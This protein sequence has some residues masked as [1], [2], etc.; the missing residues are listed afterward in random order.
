M[1]K[2][3]H[4]QTFS[5][6]IEKTVS[7]LVLATVLFGAMPAHAAKTQNASGLSAI[8]VADAETTQSG[9]SRFDGFVIPTADYQPLPA[10]ASRTYR[11]DMTAYTSSVEECDADPFTTADGSRPRNGIVAT[12]FL[13][14]G[15]RV[16]IPSLFGDK[17]LTVHDRMNKRYNRRIA[18][19]MEKKEDMREFGIH[20]NVTVEVIE[21]GDNATQWKKA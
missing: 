12:N 11:V 20:R 15:T 17:I 3:D 21:W 10:Y 2:T 19:W 16:R 13:P 4:I 7:V 18:V 9:E 8:T 1:M 5:Q 14:F 6:N